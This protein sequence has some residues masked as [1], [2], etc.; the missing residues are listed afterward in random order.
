MAD[1]P[2]RSRRKSPRETSGPEAHRRHAAAEGAD[3]SERRGTGW[4]GPFRDQAWRAQRVGR[5]AT[6]PR[7]VSGRSGEFP[8]RARAGASH[9]AGRHGFSRPA[10]RLRVP[11]HEFSLGAGATWQPTPRLQ[12]YGGVTA[13]LG[14]GGNTME[15][16]G[17]ITRVPV[18]T[19]GL[20][21]W[22][23]LF[24]PGRGGEPRPLRDQRDRALRARHAC[25][26][27]RRP[28]RTRRQLRESPLRALSPLNPTSTGPQQ[29]TSPCGRTWPWETP[30]HR[31]RGSCSPG[32]TDIA[33]RDGG[34][35]PSPRTFL[36]IGCV[37]TPAIAAVLS[38]FPG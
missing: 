23:A 38:P 14:P 21:A 31:L 36:S 30:R 26:T 27:G 5:L 24:P 16:D 13:S 15:A 10:G 20:G 37:K 3:P 33:W 9:R 1:L 17:D 22:R 6:R 25:R 29:L 2:P 11:R 4:S 32:L 28:H 34:Q 19:A 7:R 8:D 35:S 18:W 12:A